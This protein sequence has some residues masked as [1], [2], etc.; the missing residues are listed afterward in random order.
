MMNTFFDSIR[1]L[2]G[3]LTPAQVAGME[4]IIEY[5]NRTG[6]SRLHLAY[7]LATVYHETGKW[8]EPIREGA[9]RYGPSY[10]DAQS[11]RA[12]ASIYG[13]GIIRTNYALPAG[14]H[15]Q[16]YYGRGLVQITWYENYLKFEK[17]LGKPITKNPD[18]ALDWDVALPMLFTGM[19]DGMYTGIKLKD[20]KAVSASTRAI[21]NGDVSKNGGTILDYHNQFYAALA[22]YNPNEAVHSCK[23]KGLIDW[24]RTWLFGCKGDSN[25]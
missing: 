22:D 1:G 16:S 24:V 5:A 21:V 23:P 8:M 17:L 2:F 19:L 6:V 4:K 9:L 10:T 20:A 11:K 14:P 13:K 7:I 15:R 18:M 25:A 12:V 3:K